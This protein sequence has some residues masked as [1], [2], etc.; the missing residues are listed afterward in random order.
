MYKL[1]LLKP[2]VL[3]LKISCEGNFEVVDY[4]KL[5]ATFTP[6]SAL[7][8]YAYKSKRLYFWRGKKLAFNIGKFIPDAKNAFLAQ[9]PSVIILRHIILE[10]GEE[11]EEFFDD[12]KLKSAILRDQLE[13]PPQ[14]R[15]GTK[16][17]KVPDTPPEEE[18]TVRT[19]NLDVGNRN[20]RILLIKERIA[21]LFKAIPTL[22]RFYTFDGAQEKLDEILILAQRNQLSEYRDHIDKTRDSI[23][24]L[25]ATYYK[26]LDLLSQLEAIIGDAWSAKQWEAVVTNCEKI[27]E[28]AIKIGKKDLV[29]KYS[30]MIDEAR[31][32]IEEEEWAKIKLE[33]NSQPTFTDQVKPRMPV[34]DDPQAKEHLSSALNLA[35]LRFNNARTKNMFFECMKSI[36]EIV[37]L[38]EKLN[39][40]DLIQKYNEIKKEITAK[41]EQNAKKYTD[42]LE[43][44]ER[45]NTLKRIAVDLE[46]RLLFDDA[47]AKNITIRG[48]AIELDDRTSVA[49]CDRKIA[50]LDAWAKETSDSDTQKWEIPSKNIIEAQEYHLIEM[51]PDPETANRRAAE[52]LANSGDGEIVKVVTL[53]RPKF[54]NQG[55]YNSK[56]ECYAIYGTKIQE[57]SPEPA[58]DLKDD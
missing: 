45:L 9:D 47:R 37:N 36:A 51:Y 27:L 29:P 12:L 30:G 46:T 14:E 44:V 23:I 50:Q 25:R 55:P 7:G 20:R 40:P 5:T 28:V 15:I 11:P 18:V 8:I 19:E 52:I 42:K 24:N 2:H 49:E 33:E 57:K 6:T 22:C 38:A 34:K 10:S 56:G 32:K 21:L 53:V 16:N 54:M 17:I 58:L 13:N 35:E 3:A 26:D 48:L 39:R 43:K 1:P 4:K 31:G 41:L